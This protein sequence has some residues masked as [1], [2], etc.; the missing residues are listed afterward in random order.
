M[1]WKMS[2]KVHF[3]TLSTVKNSLSDFWCH[4]DLFL[5]WFGSALLLSWCFWLVEIY[6]PNGKSLLIG[7]KIQSSANYCATKEKIVPFSIFFFHYIG[8]KA[9]NNLDRTNELYVKNWTNAWNY[10]RGAHQFSRLVSDQDV[11]PT[12]I[13]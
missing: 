11:C 12:W 2:E 13:C 5:L 9:L 6:Q 3:A 4:A 7:R 10:S 1:V 8:T